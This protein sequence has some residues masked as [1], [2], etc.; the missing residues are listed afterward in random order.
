MPL[1]SL[2]KRGHILSPCFRSPYYYDKQRKIFIKAVSI[3][4]EN[5]HK[6]IQLVTF[7]RSYWGQADKYVFITVD[8]GEDIHI[9]YKMA[10]KVFLPMM[11]KKCL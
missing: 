6:K 8:L 4:I 11:L 7:F 1:H 2:T 10:R 5:K 3:M 9:L